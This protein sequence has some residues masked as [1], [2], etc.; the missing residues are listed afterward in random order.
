MNTKHTPHSATPWTVG[1]KLNVRYGNHSVTILATE[2]NRRGSY[3]EEYM[4]SEGVRPVEIGRLTSFAENDAD[5]N[6]ARIVA[7]VNA[8]AGMDDPQAAIEKL[9]ADN[10]AMLELLQA[11]ASHL[12][13]NGLDG[14]RIHAYL[15]ALNK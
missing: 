5:A 10:A 1:E 13:K 7:C 3:T 6:A 15:S 9:R 14:R 11:A 12:P 8:C 4:D 2:D